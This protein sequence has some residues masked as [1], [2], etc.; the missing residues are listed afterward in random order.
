MFCI[1]ISF[2]YMLPKRCALTHSVNMYLYLIKYYT[3]KYVQKGNVKFQCGHVHRYDDLCTVQGLCG[4]TRMAPTR[5]MLASQQGLCR[6]PYEIPCGCTWCLYRSCTATLKLPWIFSGAP[7]TGAPGNIQGNLD[8]YE[9][10]N[11]LVPVIIPNNPVNFMYGFC[12]GLL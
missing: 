10:C 12:M 6:R 2:W 9:S 3:Y 8:R 4:K 11:I 7:L 1:W 5:S